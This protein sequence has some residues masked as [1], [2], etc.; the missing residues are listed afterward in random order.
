MHLEAVI[1]KNAASTC[2][3]QASLTFYC[4]PLSPLTQHA[5]SLVHGC[6]PEPPVTQSLHKRVDVHTSV[7]SKHPV[8]EL[9]PVHPRPRAKRSL[10]TGQERSRS[11]LSWAREAHE[12]KRAGGGGGAGACGRNYGPCNRGERGGWAAATAGA[13][14]AHRLLQRHSANC[15]CNFTRLSSSNPKNCWCRRDAW[16]D[17]LRIDSR[18]CR[19]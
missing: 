1:I 6:S 8:H 3:T 13:F 9:S 14:R 11:Q 4:T 7:E 18:R 17:Q 16:D 2:Q 15:H 10:H 19:C 5:G 12:R